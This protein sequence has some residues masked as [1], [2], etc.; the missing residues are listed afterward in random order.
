MNARS[1]GISDDH[2]AQ[3][4]VA[5]YDPAFVDPGHGNSKAAWA[6]VVVMLVAVLFGTLFFFLDLPMLVWASAG[7]LVIGAVLWPILAR[8]GL[9]VQDH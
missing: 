7:L 5:D 6:S 4:H 2:A 8:A 1:N 9:G 3:L